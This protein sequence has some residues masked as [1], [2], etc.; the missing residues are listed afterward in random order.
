[1][2]FHIFSLLF[3]RLNLLHFKDTS[4]SFYSTK[5]Q[6][7][8]DAMPE[9]CERDSRFPSYAA[10]FALFCFSSQTRGS[11]LQCKYIQFHQRRQLFG[12]KCP[13]MLVDGA[14]A[15]E[16]SLITLTDHLPFCPVNSLSLRA[17]CVRRKA[18]RSSFVARSAIWW[19]YRE[20][21]NQWRSSGQSAWAS[22]RGCPAENKAASTELTSLSWGQ[23]S[24]WS[25]YQNQSPWYSESLF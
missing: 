7:L 8:C 20:T 16:L 2:Y 14:D 17:V 13:F 23:R 21:L 11:E 4:S 25:L 9:A 1:M 12:W 18:P 6:R 15:G 10:V 22:E 24:C 5:E 3:P 19:S